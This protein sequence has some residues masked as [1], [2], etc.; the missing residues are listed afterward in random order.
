MEWM[1]QKDEFHIYIWCKQISCGHSGNEPDS[2]TSWQKIQLLHLTDGWER[3]EPTKVADASIH[4][5]VYFSERG[6]WNGAWK[7]TIFMRKSTAKHVQLVT[8]KMELTAKCWN[9]NALMLSVNE[10]KLLAEQNEWQKL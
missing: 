3:K 5:P 7:S 8:Y 2:Y 9:A 1:W 10:Q 4:M 6:S